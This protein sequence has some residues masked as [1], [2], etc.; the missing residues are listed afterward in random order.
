MLLIVCENSLE[1]LIDRC[2]IFKEV[3]DE[4]K[5]FCNYKGIFWLLMLK[6][7]IGFDE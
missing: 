7:L 5:V 3:I 4:F 2:R 6:L 1:E